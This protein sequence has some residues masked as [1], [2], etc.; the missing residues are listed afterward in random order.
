MR[1]LG[2]L[3]DSFW[4]HEGTLRCREIRLYFIFL[5]VALRT[6]WVG[7]QQLALSLFMPADH[8]KYHRCDRDVMSMEFIGIAKALI[9]RRIVYHTIRPIVDMTMETE[10]RNAGSAGLGMG[11]IAPELVRGLNDSQAY[12]DTAVRHPITIGDLFVLSR[13]DLNECRCP[14][15]GGTYVWRRHNIL[16]REPVPIAGGNGSGQDHVLSDHVRLYGPEQRRHGVGRQSVRQT[17]HPGVDVLRQ[18][19][20]EFESIGRRFGYR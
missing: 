15:R 13:S 19:R 17:V 18:P 5:I 3:R 16:S 10:N 1:H 6:D 4:L 7:K 2:K 12:F 20:R 14:G 11:A 9:G 8:P